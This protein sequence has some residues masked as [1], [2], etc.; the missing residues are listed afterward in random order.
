MLSVKYGS[1]IGAGH[2]VTARSGEF[3]ERR[4]GRS[5]GSEKGCGSVHEILLILGIGQIVCNATRGDC[6]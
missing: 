2:A 1:D 5:A 3:A 6:T 4:F